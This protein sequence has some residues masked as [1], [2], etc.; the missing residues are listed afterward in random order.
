MTPQTSNAWNPAR[1]TLVVGLN[2]IGDTLMAM[3]AV[4][5]WRAANPEA[6]LSVLARGNLAPLWRLHSAADTIIEYESTNAGTFAAARE[7]RTGRF[8]RAVSLPNSFRTAIIPYLARIPERI[9]T[10]GQLRS[11][12]LT[13]RVTHGPELAAKHQAFEY[14]QLLGLDAP[15]HISPPKLKISEG[16]REL[17]ESRFEDLFQ[18][19]V[20]LIPGAARGPSKRWPA[21]HFAAVG[22]NLAE[23][24]G[25]GIALFGGPDDSDLCDSICEQ[26]G[27]H[28][29][30]FAGKTNL[31]EWA[32]ML[33]ACRL[34]ICNDSGGMHLAASVGTPLIALYGLTDP[35]KTGPLGT[36]CTILRDDS[37]AASRDIPRDSAAARAALAAITPQRVIEAAR[38]VI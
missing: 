22:K 18:P 19:V 13:R 4:E 16:L 23:T 12:L 36:N 1:R 29:R 24:R 8:D 28:A 35:A 20:G 6:H 31:K 9:G 26:I 21:E 10:A 17:A 25:C 7:L 15:E 34:V 14:F 32:A 37:L 33:A 30:S 11:L 2:W 38:R 27:D 3:P 5:A